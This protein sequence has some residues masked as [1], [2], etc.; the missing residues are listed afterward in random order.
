LCLSSCILHPLPTIK[1]LRCQCQL[2]N[3]IARRLGK[4]SLLWT[5]SPY[6]VFRLVPV[7][8]STCT[9]TSWPGA[10]DDSLC[11]A[12]HCTGWPRLVSFPQSPLQAWPRRHF[13]R[14]PRPLFTSLRLL[15]FSLSLPS[16]VAPI[17][18]SVAA[19]TVADRL[20][21]PDTE[22]PW[23]HPRRATSTSSSSCNDTP[24]ALSRREPRYRQDGL[25][26]EHGREGGQGP[27]RGD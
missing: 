23:R 24:L 1:H 22:R 5:A 15:D 16:L 14:V 4:S 18:I 26:N 9:S 27:E 13:R 3:P 6:P 2:V 20:R 8:P 12:L 25:R 17:S 19:A 21:P 10:R 11:S 7:A